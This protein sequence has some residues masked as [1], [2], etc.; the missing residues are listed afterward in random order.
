[1]YTILL[2]Y[3]YIA[4]RLQTD[5]MLLSRIKWIGSISMIMSAVAISLSPTIST[6]PIAFVGFFIAHVIWTT[7]AIIMKDKPLLL[8]QAGF[9]PID[10]WAMIIRT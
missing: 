10:V 3:D 6:M 4:Y 1:M 7:S 9:I 8:Q 5:A 2:A